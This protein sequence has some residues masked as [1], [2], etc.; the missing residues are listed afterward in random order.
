MERLVDDLQRLRTAVIDAD[1]DGAF[2]TGEVL[3]SRYWCVACHHRFGDA[4]ARHWSTCPI[5]LAFADPA[6]VDPFA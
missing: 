2:S 6:R 5:A 1:D 4:L 3:T